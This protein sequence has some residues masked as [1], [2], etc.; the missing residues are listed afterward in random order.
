MTDEADPHDLIIPENPS[1]LPPRVSGDAGD[2]WS[3]VLTKV[4]NRFMRIERSI[5]DMG[6]QP[7]AD[8]N[9]VP[10]AVA[11]ALDAKENRVPGG[12]VAASFFESVITDM[13]ARLDA[14]GKEIDALRQ[15]IAGQQTAID[16]L[17]QHIADMANTLGAPTDAAS[18][19]ATAAPDASPPGGI[20]ANDPA[21]PS[22]YVPSAGPAAAPV[23]PS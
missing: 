7:K 11:A 19:P 8:P 14:S 9:A 4:Q 18:P 17:R 13:N 15:T 22:S 12:F 2:S 10:A 20:P 21:A 16:E 5:F 23:E 1:A 6:G 3:T